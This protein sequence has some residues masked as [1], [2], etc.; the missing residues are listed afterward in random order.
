MPSY[1]AFL[2]N[3][4]AISLAELAA[5]IPSFQLNAVVDK[6][7]A[8]FSAQEELSAEFINHLGGTIFLA[9]GIGNGSLGMDDVPKVFVKELEKAK[10]G[11]VTFLS[12]I[13]I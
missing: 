1:A 9:Q 5:S 4:P 7:V 3:Q 10:R 13:H 11:K 6:A 12:L 8:L 2:G